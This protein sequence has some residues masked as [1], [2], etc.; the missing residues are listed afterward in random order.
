VIPRAFSIILAKAGQGG[1]TA[2]RGLQEL[3][4]MDSNTDSQCLAKR[5]TTWIP[6]YRLRPTTWDQQ[7][8]ATM[9]PEF[10]DHALAPDECQ[11]CEEP[12]YGYH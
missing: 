2:P 11:H 10:D 3:P 5:A 8:V 4:L 1:M 9:T 6:S 7:M 12:T